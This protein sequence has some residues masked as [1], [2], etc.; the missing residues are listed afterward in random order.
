MKKDVVF[1][2]RAVNTV[3]VTFLSVTGFAYI[4]SEASVSNSQLYI[5]LF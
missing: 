1:N 5:Q 4:K 2:L 3:R